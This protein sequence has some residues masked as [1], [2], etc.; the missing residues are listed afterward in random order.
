MTT[1][2]A[3]RTR[4][5]RTVRVLSVTY[6]A[7]LLF[8]YGIT[9][10][11]L[12][13]TPQYASPTLSGYASQI[14]ILCVLTGF[15]AMATIEITKRLLHLRGYLYYDRLSS[16]AGE[17]LLQLS[18]SEPWSGIPPRNVRRR[19]ALR[20]D[21]P[22]EQLVAQIGHAADGLIANP[23]AN[24]SLLEDLIE[25]R[26]RVAREV[27]ALNPDVDSV[28][29]NQASVQ[30]TLDDLLVVVG[31]EWR[32]QL[33]TACC[34]LSLVYGVFILGYA[35]G[36]PL[37]KLGTAVATFLLGGFLGGLFRDIIALVE[38]SR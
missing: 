27:G 18:V 9:A 6:P 36:P 17:R 22:L 10:W 35:E 21:M 33:R 29:S 3:R 26:Q 5:Q 30:A 13:T 7:I 11:F 8:A 23:S 28:R 20:L 12:P 15:G 2:I 16:L 1:R 37:L 34:G 25:A 14:A 32:W 38:R 4:L 19:Y 24:P 31:N